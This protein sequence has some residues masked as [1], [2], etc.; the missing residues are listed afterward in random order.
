MVGDYELLVFDLP[1]DPAVPGCYWLGAVRSAA[2][3]GANRPRRRADIRRREGR[4]PACLR[5]TLALPPLGGHPIKQ[6]EIAARQLHALAENLGAGVGIW[7]FIW[8]LTS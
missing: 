1:A 6:D 2:S 8:S 3:P 7:V 5:Q 4:S